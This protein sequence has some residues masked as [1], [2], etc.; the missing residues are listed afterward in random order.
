MPRTPTPA[1]TPAGPHLTSVDDVP[2]L[3]VGALELDDEA[4]LTHAEALARLEE[5]EETL[6]AISRGEIDAFVVSDG[7][8][9]RRVFTLSTADRP[10]RRFV[11]N[12]RDGAATL[13]PAGVVLYANRRLAEL[14]SCSTEEIRGSRLTTFLSPDAIAGWHSAREYEVATIELDLLDVQGIEIPVLVGISPLGEEDLLTCLTFTDLSIQ[15]AQDQEIARLS[16][17]QS[18][19]LLDLQQAQ[20]ALTLQATHD[21]LTGL[22]NRQ[23]LVDRINQALHR[24]TR[25]HDYTAVYFIDL[26]GFKHV[27]D[28]HGHAVGNRVLQEVADRLVSALRK[29]DTVARIG[30]DEFVVLAPG[31]AS[32]TKAAELG[33]RL[34]AELARYSGGTSERVCASVGISISESGRGSAEVLL[35]EADTAMYQAKSLGGSRSALFDEEIARRVDVRNSAQTTLKVALDEH[36]VVPFYQPI[37]DLTSGA[38]AGFEALARLIQR[39]GTI[40]SPAAFIPAAEESGLVLPL[41]AEVLEQ[42]C[43]Q[44]C[45][46]PSTASDETMAVAVN[47]SSR[48][49]EQG[50]L[51]EVVRDILSTTGLSPSRLHLELTETAIM[52]LDPEILRQLSGIRDLG[53]QIGLDDFG[54]GYASLTHLRRLPLDFVKVDRSFV[55]GLGSDPGD[56]RIVGAVIDLARNLGLRSIG[57]GVETPEQLHRLIELGCDQ[58]QGYLFAR[59]AAPDDLSFG[60]YPLDVGTKH[61]Q[62]AA[63]VR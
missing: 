25:S 59:P 41:G 22:P 35:H 37:V 60:S 4:S 17:I 62:V 52:D 56:E 29:M 26:D 15:K 3:A 11:E 28:T 50:D 9:D 46:W 36:R 2:H 47:V 14:L 12:M 51:T 40:L 53:V 19:Q 63:R 5:V 23:L 49:F 48:Q 31:I 39:N 34:A 7:A 27:N 44:A 20:A 43:A 38:V 10:Y 61:A 55:H 54:T 33:A 42:A 13:S 24:A 58:A 8:S 16:A 6:Q 45:L 30:G 21:A 18:K 1:I 57:E 32:R